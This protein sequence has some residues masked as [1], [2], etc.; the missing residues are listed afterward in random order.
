VEKIAYC[1][2]VIAN[3]RLRKGKLRLNKFGNRQWEM[4]NRQWIIH[5]A[6][7]MRKDC[8]LPIGHCEF[9]IGE[10]EVAVQRIWLSAIGNE[11]SAMDNSPRGPDEK[12]L[13]IAD[14]ALRISDW[15]EGRS[16]ST[17]LAI[18]NRQ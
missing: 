16:G 4:N 14:C 11:Q 5:R 17:D 8:S 7:R 12:G 6:D 13:L 10:K 18:G 1:Q 2:L 15:G 9:P 3:F